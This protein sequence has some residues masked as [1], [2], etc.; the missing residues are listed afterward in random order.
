MAMVMLPYIAYMDPMGNDP[1]AGDL[2][3]PKT[4]KNRRSRNCG[5]LRQVSI[6]A[7]ATFR[8]HQHSPTGI[9]LDETCQWQRL[10]HGVSIPGH[11]CLESMFKM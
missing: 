8:D 7:A 11:V 2:R 10:G 5:I 4:A 9:R 1:F 3:L 6:A